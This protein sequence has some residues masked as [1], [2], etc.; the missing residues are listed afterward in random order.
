MPRTPIHPGIIL[1]DEIEEL[2]LSVRELAARLEVPANRLYQIVAGK[3]NVTADTALRLAQ[4]FGMSAE[5][6]MNLQSIYELDLARRD[7]GGALNH[8]S[9]RSA[10]PSPEVRP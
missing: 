5:F 1:Q 6:W 8:I 3:R 10:R 4:F 9:K 7:L 2:G